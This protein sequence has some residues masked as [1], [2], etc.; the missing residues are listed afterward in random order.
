MRACTCWL[1]AP[2]EDIGGFLRSPRST[3][4]IRFTSG[5]CCCWLRQ[6]PVINGTDSIRFGAVTTR[7]APASLVGWLLSCLAGLLARWL[8]R[9][10]RSWSGCFARVVVVVVVGQAGSV[11]IDGKCKKLY[12]KNKLFRISSLIALIILIQYL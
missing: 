6:R 1:L 7:S 12:A 4:L 5:F 11:R 2:G 8:A 3:Q 10:D 9:L